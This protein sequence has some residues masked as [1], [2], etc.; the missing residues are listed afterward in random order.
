MFF[1]QIIPRPCVVSIFSNSRTKFCKDTKSPSRSKLPQSK[2]TVINV[3]ISDPGWLW[4]SWV[5]F[6]VY[7]GINKSL[8][9]RGIILI[10][11]M[12]KMFLSW[13]LKIKL[14]ANLLKIYFSWCKTRW[15]TRCFFRFETLD[16][17]WHIA[18]IYQVSAAAAGPGQGPEW[19]FT[20][21]DIV[22]R[23]RMSWC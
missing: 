18:E 19:G 22:T 5:M 9:V 12:H 15:S 7:Q 3:I 6:W 23:H 2:T 10:N 14:S 13:I 11:I 17:E 21:L 1:V 16:C 20:P 8:L 4:S